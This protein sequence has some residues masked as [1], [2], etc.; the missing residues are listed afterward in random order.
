MVESSLS[1]YYIIIIVIIVTIITLYICIYT[2][3]T[4]HLADHQ[5]QWLR[6]LSHHGVKAIVG[7]VKEK[8]KKKDK[9]STDEE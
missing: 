2:G 9:K 4:D 8:N 7:H 1:S 6:V 3:P 5:L